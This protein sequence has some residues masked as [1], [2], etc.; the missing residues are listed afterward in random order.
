[1]DKKSLAIVL[2]FS[3][4]HALPLYEVKGATVKG[5]SFSVKLISHAS[6]IRGTVKF[7]KSAIF[8]QCVNLMYL[9]AML[10]GLDK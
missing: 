2:G 10:S 8:C 5:Q 7:F 9:Y 4:M 6:R 3:L 1:M